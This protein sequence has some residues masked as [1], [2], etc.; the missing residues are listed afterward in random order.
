MRWVFCMALPLLAL[1]WGVQIADDRSTWLLQ[2]GSQLL[3][4]QRFTLPAFGV[5]GVACGVFILDRFLAKRKEFTIAM[6][7]LRRHP[8]RM[9]I[10]IGAFAMMVWIAGE[11]AYAAAAAVFDGVRLHASTIFGDTQTVT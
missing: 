7:G 4:S 11:I 10:E 1:I 5:V 6:R 8:V 9:A 3:P 2:H